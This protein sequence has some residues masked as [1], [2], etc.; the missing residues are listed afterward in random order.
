[1]VNEALSLICKHWYTHIDFLSN[2]GNAEIAKLRKKTFFKLMKKIIPIDHMIYSDHPANIT[3]TSGNLVTISHQNAQE[4]YFKESI[5]DY[6]LIHVE[7]KYSIYTALYSK[8]G[9]DLC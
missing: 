4:I 8:K 6:I 2:D 5:G 7:C 1:M 3:I 9:L